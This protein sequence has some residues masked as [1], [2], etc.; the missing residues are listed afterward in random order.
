MDGQPYD[1]FFFFFECL[2]KVRVWSLWLVSFLI[3]LRAYQIPG[4]LHI[5]A[6]GVPVSCALEGTERHV[7]RHTGVSPSALIISIKSLYT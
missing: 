4:M 5:D 7:T 1:L 2:S 3:G 6:I